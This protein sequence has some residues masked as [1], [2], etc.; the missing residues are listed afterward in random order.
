VLLTDEQIGSLLDK[1]GVDA[2][3]YYVDKLSSF[4]IKNGAKVKNHYE[5]ILKW[6]NEDAVVRGNG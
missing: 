6:W 2:F 5:T 4:I 3:D 1:M